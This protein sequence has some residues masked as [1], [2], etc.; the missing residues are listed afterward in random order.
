MEKRKEENLTTSITLHLDAIIVT[1]VLMSMT[2]GF[3]MNINIQIYNFKTKLA[4][5]YTTL[6]FL[7]HLTLF[8]LHLEIGYP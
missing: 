2:G 8:H 4:S 6:S 1:D 7:F 5:H 3:S